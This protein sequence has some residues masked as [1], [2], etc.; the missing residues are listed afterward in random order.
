MNA[1]R[2][3]WVDWRLAD[4]TM[5]QT[6]LVGQ[7]TEFQRQHPN[8]SFRPLK[9]NEVAALKWLKRYNSGE[10]NAYVNQS[11][12]AAEGLELLAEIAPGVGASAPPPAWLQ[13]VP[14]PQQ[15]A[16]PV[17][18]SASQSAGMI[19]VAKAEEKGI[20]LTKPELMGLIMEDVAVIT[21]VARKVGK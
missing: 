13:S 14:G 11:A 20:N 6:A 4:A 5:R 1:A 9:K 16:A 12:E 7:Y 10:F 17:A 18:D 19:L 15:A 8:M 21:A 3:K 2:Q